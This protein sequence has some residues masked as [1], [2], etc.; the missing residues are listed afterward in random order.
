MTKARVYL[1]VHIQQKLRTPLGVLYGCTDSSTAML[2]DAGKLGG[3]RISELGVR[4]LSSEPNPD[5]A[6]PGLNLSQAQG[7]LT[8][9]RIASS[10]KTGYTWAE[11]IDYLHAGRRVILQHDMYYLDDPTG[12]RAHVGHAMLLQ[13][14]RHFDGRWQILGNN[15]AMGQAHWYSPEALKRAATVFADQTNVPGDGLRYLISRVVPLMAVE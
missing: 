4:R 15:P 2:E 3:T 11:L 1:P 5:P 12:G 13:A 10:D 9:L 14:A 6:S 7:V 8:K